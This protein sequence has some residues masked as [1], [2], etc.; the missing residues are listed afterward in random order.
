VSMTVSLLAPPT[1]RG[2]LV[3]L[4]ITC[5]ALMRVIAPIV[6]GPLYDIDKISPFLVMAG[7]LA[8]SFLFEVLLIFRVPRLSQLALGKKDDQAEETKDEEAER[9]ALLENFRFSGEQ[10]AMLLSNWQ[11]KKADFEAG[12]SIDELGLHPVNLVPPEPSLAEKHAL[13]V[14][15]AD[16]L[17]EHNFKRWTEHRAVVECFCR[18]AFPKLRDYP[19]EWISRMGDIEHV[20]ESHIM[21]EKQWERFVLQR[22]PAL[23]AAG[24]SDFHFVQA[25]SEFAN[26][27]PMDSGTNSQTSTGAEAFV[28][29][30]DA[31][32]SAEPIGA[33]KL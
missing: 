3:S 16:M 22:S 26:S 30:T 27:P 11:Q 29:T 4:T 17:R 15:F 32:T 6:A 18:N 23:P 12:K 1:K 9:K 7:A 25:M 20:L 21:L 19:M 14:W 31:A 24:A 13:G 2:S 10:L 5:Q 28:S 8:V 33:T